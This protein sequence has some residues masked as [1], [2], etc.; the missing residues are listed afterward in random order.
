MQPQSSNQPPRVSIIMPSYNT[1]T[2]IAAS[3]DSVFQQ[4]F[5]DFEVVLVNDGSPDTP[6]L[7][8][9]L[10]PY[11]ET[12]ADQ[13]VY[14]RQ[15][16]K[17]CAGA[18][19]TAIGRAR[20]EFLAF[21]DSDDAWL[22]D[23]LSAQMQLF[24]QDP[25]LDL[26]YA[27]GLRVGDPTRPVEFM[28][29]CP[30]HGPADFQALVVERCQI[31]ISTVVARKGALL[32]AGLFDENL[33]RCDD[34]D[35]WLRAAFHGAQIAYTREV[36]ARLNGGRPGSLGAS[37]ARMSEA[38][39]KILEKTLQ[40]LPLSPADREVVQN[41]AVEIRARYLLEEGKHQLQQEE[42]EQARTSFNEAN[43]Y[44]RLSKVSLVLVGLAIAPRA[45]RKLAS[46]MEG[47]HDWSIRYLPG[48]R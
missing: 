28:T 43:T 36:Q 42:F 29:R 15:E 11:L 34:Y 32:R 1:A 25:T 48:Q 22:P 27:N 19:N 35:M 8:R 46:L 26:V 24:E 6:E 44:L 47:F 2:L 7:E 39:W 12:H 21:L 3:L 13:I 18:R 20:G 5:R 37:R 40:T 10:V 41:R 31:S 16:N 9:V 23:H 14:I 30:S 17:R 38:Y 33:A 45:T 4:T